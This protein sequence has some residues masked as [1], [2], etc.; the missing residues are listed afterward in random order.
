MKRTGDLV[1][2]Q[3]LRMR[4][5]YGVCEPGQ[6]ATGGARDSFLQAYHVRPDVLSSHGVRTLSE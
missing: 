5:A 4:W 1:P 6:D 3:P 2:M